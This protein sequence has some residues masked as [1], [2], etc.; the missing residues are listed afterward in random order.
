M[1]A[2]PLQCVSYL[3]IVGE[4]ENKTLVYHFPELFYDLS[5]LFGCLQLSYSLFFTVER[6][7]AHPALKHIWYSA[8]S[9]ISGLIVPVVT[10]R[11]AKIQPPKHPTA[12]KEAKQ[13]QQLKQNAIRNAATA[14]EKSPLASATTAYLLASRFFC[15]CGAFVPVRLGESCGG[16]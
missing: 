4:H 14:L 7:L 12:S 15:L 9:F 2:R 5:A 16:Q 1:W 3:R 11:N 10:T 13:I 6:T 8:C